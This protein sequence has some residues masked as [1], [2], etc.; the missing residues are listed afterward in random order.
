M[1]I[2]LRRCGVLEPA[3]AVYSILVYRYLKFAFYF[4]GKMVYNQSARQLTVMVGKIRKM[5]LIL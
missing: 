2:K 1:Q 4:L 3:K 5:E